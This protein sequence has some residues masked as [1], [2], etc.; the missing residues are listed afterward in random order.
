[1][2][3]EVFTHQDEAGVVS[4][5]PAEG[6]HADFWV[7]VVME[8]LT[9]AVGVSTQDEAGLKPPQQLTMV[10]GVKKKHICPQR[11]LSALLHHQFHH[12]HLLFR[13]GGCF[14][15]S[16][17]LYCILIGWNASEVTWSDCRVLT[18]WEDSFDNTSYFSLNCSCRSSGGAASSPVQPASL[19]LYRG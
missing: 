17:Q 11:P 12:H 8:N 13:Y 10:G 3:D 5:P 19:T 14:F 6:R 1:M 16:W 15:F 7:L 18:R 4:V 9:S 2:K